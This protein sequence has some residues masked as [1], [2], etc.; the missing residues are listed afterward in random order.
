MLGKRPE[1]CCDSKQRKALQH[2]NEMFVSPIHQHSKL[3]V[4]TP[5]IPK[6]TVYSRATYNPKNK[7]TDEIKD[8]DAI[9]K[10]LIK[11]IGLMSPKDS[12]VAI[13]QEQINSIRREVDYLTS[14]R[15]RALK[16]RDDL[17]QYL[18]INTDKVVPIEAVRQIIMP[19][20]AHIVTPDIL[21]PIG[22]TE[23]QFE[24]L[25]EGQPVSNFSTGP[26]GGDADIKQ[27]LDEA[28]E[29]S[30]SAPSG[31]APESE[32]APSG[33]AP[34]SESDSDNEGVQSESDN[35]SVDTEADYEEYHRLKEL[36]KWDNDDVNSYME[37]IERR[38]ELSEEPEEPEEEEEE[39]KAEE[40]APE[41]EKKMSKFI[42]K[43]EYNI[44]YVKPTTMFSFLKSEGM[45]T[46]RI[47]KGKGYKKALIALIKKNDLEEK[48]KDYIGK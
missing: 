14:H 23:D 2:N 6:E 7:V 36:D 39:P 9:I 32:S 24:E 20:E 17:L 35:E 44:N 28:P 27:Q 25:P 43:L 34:E 5:Y 46:E 10:A 18:T 22:S 26:M 33:A 48:L 42:K 38:P 8:R 3:G 31:A 13:L 29:G 41:E 12:R 37:L 4:F 19:P 30:L 15:D 1:Y 47:K 45:D 40:I 21:T 16:Q 11:R